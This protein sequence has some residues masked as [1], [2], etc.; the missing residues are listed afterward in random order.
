MKQ[1]Y[2]FF[3]IPI[4]FAG[5]QPVHEQWISMLSN[6]GLAIVFA[7]TCIF[8]FLPAIGYSGYRCICWIGERIDSLLDSHKEWMERLVQSNELLS[9][10]A[11]LEPIWHK[12]EADRIISIHENVKNTSSKVDEIHR[13]IILKKAKLD[14]QQQ[15][16]RKAGGTG[17]AS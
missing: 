15:S 1:K 10:S 11:N 13:I 7:M 14:E 2:L 8:I 6:N 9:K 17:T 12:K 16:S 4:L 5:C 3:C